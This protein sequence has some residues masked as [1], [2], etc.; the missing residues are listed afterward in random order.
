MT[1]ESV[2]P[3]LIAGSGRDAKPHVLFVDDNE[4]A[5]P[6][7]LSAM[8][9]EYGVD[10]RLRH[11]ESTIKTDLDWANLI[12]IDYFLTYWPERDETESVARKPYDGL[13]AAAS[14]RSALLP[15]LAERLPGEVPARSVAFALWSS[16]LKEATFDLP[17]V[18]LPHVFSRD[19][20]LEWAFRRSDLLDD[21]GIKQIALLAQAATRLP[22]Q[23]PS[24]PSDA[25]RQMMVMLGLIPEFGSKEQ[26]QDGNFWRDDARDDVL[27]CR[28]PIHE[29]SERSH[30]LALLRW[31]LHRIFP[32]PCF[33][34]DEQQLCARLRVDALEGGTASGPSLLE[35]LS[36]Y[37]YIGTLA[38][39]GG[40]RWWRSGVED[41][42]FNQTGGQPGS[43]IAVA[44]VAIRH[45][46][47]A[48]RTW[49]RPVIVL[50]GDLARST[51]FA[52]VDRTVRVRPD[53]WPVFADDAFALQDLA[54]EDP[55]L[56]ALVQPA[57]RILLAPSIAD[58]AS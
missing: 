44:E 1:T 34:L 36:P 47:A 42:L 48:N 30:G 4:Q 11:P 24:R 5:D 53:D 18:V 51:E 15:S 31:L 17:E 20:N 21:L 35:T 16:N 33:L 57:D 39:F 2:N 23:W 43:P 52:E 28:P 38:G 25:E 3:Y 27:N 46:A 26:V 8:L 54:R 56:R 13:S 12:V 29:L 45:G 10:A 6:A 7:Q 55:T 41:W 14:M 19:N 9:L 22:G 50:N 49:L 32:Y 37:Q 58:D 40:N